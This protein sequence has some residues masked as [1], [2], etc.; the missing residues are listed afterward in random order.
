[1]EEKK[2]AEANGELDINMGKLPILLI[3]EGGVTKELGQSRTIE[4]LVTEFTLLFM[5][6][7]LNIT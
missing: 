3:S 2:T 4:R 6:Y 1:M 5:I 7:T